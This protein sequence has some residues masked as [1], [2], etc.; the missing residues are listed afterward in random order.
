MVSV[1]SAACI[2]YRSICRWEIGG[3]Q[4][5]LRG[6]QRIAAGAGA[7]L[8]GFL[9]LDQRGMVVV[10]YDINVVVIVYRIGMAGLRGKQ[11]LCRTIK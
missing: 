8:G 9:V 2:R 7:V 5:A 1:R 4:A 6:C 11:R 10:G 3:L